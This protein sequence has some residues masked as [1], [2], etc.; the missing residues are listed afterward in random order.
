MPVLTWDNASEKLYETG[1]SN[2]VLYVMNSDGSYAE[3]VAWNGVSALNES[4]SGG[5][6]SPIYADNVKY[7]NLISDEE[8]GATIEAYMFPDEWM[9]CDGSKMIAP[10]VYAGQQN[11]KKF[12]LSYMTLVGNDAEG[13]DY[14]YKLH[15]LYN[16]DAAPSEK[17]HSTVNESPEAAS[18]SWTIS[19]TK[20]PSGIEGV[21]PLASL[22]IDSTADGV[23]EAT[24]K[25]I[26][27]LL[28]GGE[29]AEKKAKMPTPAEIVA[30]MNAA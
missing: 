23:T 8:I 18:M 20:I 26:K 12:A 25:K 28:W 19:T 3:G 14:G 22:T 4:P 11:R 30:L 21:K 1:V 9:E 27:E 13:T 7:L 10:G 6:A 29:G 17:S 2:V 24:M 16:C 15:L 5:E